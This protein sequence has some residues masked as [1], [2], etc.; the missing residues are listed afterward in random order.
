MENFW[1]FVIGFG[2]GGVTVALVTFLSG[3]MF[4][5]QRR[6]RRTRRNPRR[7]K[8][9]PDDELKALRKMTGLE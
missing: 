6:Y 7:A 4:E 3:P 1:S 9:V 2:L 5:E 8:A